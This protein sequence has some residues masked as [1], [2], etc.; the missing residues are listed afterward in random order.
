MEPRGRRGGHGALGR[1]RPDRRAPRRC[2]PAA[3]PHGPGER[4]GGVRLLRALDRDERHRDGARRAA[5]AARA[6]S[7]ALQ[8]RARGPDLRGEPDHRAVHRAGR[9]LVLAGLRDPRRP[10]ADDRPRRGR[11]PPDRGGPPRPGRSAPPPARRGLPDR[12]RGAGRGAGRRPGDRADEPRRPRPRGAGPPPRPV[13]L[14]G[15]APRARPR[16]DGGAALRRC[17]RRRRRAGRRRRVARLPHPG[18]RTPTRRPGRI[19]G[20]GGAAGCADTVAPRPGGRQ[21]ARGGPRARRG[22]RGRRARGIGEAADGA[23]AAAPRGRPGSAGRR[24]GPGFR[25]GSS[26]PATPS[27]RAGDW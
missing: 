15:G 12:R 24:A 17:P 16:T 25:S 1:E 23:G 21:G 11:G 18:A 27:R 2:P 7:R 19:R 20:D 22:R 4:G 26:P 8:R 14:P 3:D 13:A 6:G 5:P 9:R 10:P